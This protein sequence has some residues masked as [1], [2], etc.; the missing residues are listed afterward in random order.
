MYNYIFPL[1]NT[2]I[3]VQLH[4]C[5]ENTFVNVQL[6][7]FYKNTVV[8]VQLHLD[9]K[10]NCVLYF[11]VHAT[12]IFPTTTRYF[13]FFFPS[14]LSFLFIERGENLTKIPKLLIFSSFFQLY[15]KFQEMLR[16]EIFNF[17][18]ISEKYH[19]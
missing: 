15:S 13:W 5:T 6:C 2:F 11:Y 19:N 9:H 18:K 10:Y 1:K 16:Y 14:D 17:G 3:I 7:F 4:F 8:N 12:W